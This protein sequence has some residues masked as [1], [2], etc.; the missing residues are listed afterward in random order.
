M[1]LGINYL[2]EHNILIYKIKNLNND[3]RSISPKGLDKIKIISSM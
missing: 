1:I 2:F 3:D